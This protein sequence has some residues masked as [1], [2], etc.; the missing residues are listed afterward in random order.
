[1]EEKGGVLEEEEEEE[2][3]T[4]IHVSRSLYNNCDTGVVL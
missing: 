3:K 1:M 2:E 4:F